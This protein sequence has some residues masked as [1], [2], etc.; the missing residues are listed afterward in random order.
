MK[1]LLCM[2]LTIL[3]IV[4][5]MPLS[6]AVGEIYLSSYSVNTSY[7]SPN[8]ECMISFGVSGVSNG[9]IAVSTDLSSAFQLTGGNIIQNVAVVNGQTTPIPFRYDG[10]SKNLVITII[11]T[12]TGVPNTQT[13]LIAEAQE[14]ASMQQPSGSTEPQL[15]IN[16]NAQ[17][18][19]PG[20][21]AEVVV[22]VKN[23]SNYPATNIYCTVSTDGS[24]VYPST[25][26]NRLSV[27]TIMPGM[28]QTIA[29]PVTVTADASAGYLNIGLNF[30]Y[31]GANGNLIEQTE[32]IGVT[33]D[34]SMAHGMSALLNVSAA[35]LEQTVID[36]SNTADL[37]VQLHNTGTWQAT[38]IE[39]SLEG[40]TANG[41][42]LNDSVG[43]KRFE[44][45]A[46]GQKI[47]TSFPLRVSPDLE[48]GSHS[49]TVKI[50]Y[51]NGVERVETTEEV[52]L[53]VTRN[54]SAGLALSSAKLNTNTPGSSNRVK[55][56]LGLVNKDT[57]AV[58]NIRT[59]IE[60][61]STATFTLD[62]TFGSVDLT[63]L[64]GGASATLEFPLYVSEALATGNYPLTVVTKYLDASGTEQTKETEIYLYINRP[65]K[66]PDLP[67]ETLPD[68]TPR[69][70]ISKYNVSTELIEAGNEFTLDFTLKNTS[71]STAI[72]N[73]KIGLSSADGVYLPVEGSSSFYEPRIDADGE[74]DFSIRL[75][76]KRDAET[77][78]YPLTI[79]IDY[80]NEKNTSYNVT[81]TLSFSVN[82]EQRLELNNV[83]FMPNGMSPGTLSLQYINKGKAVLYN[84]SVRVEGPFTSEYGVQYIGNFGIGSSD[85]F[86]DYLTPTE[87]GELTGKLI[88]EF[89]DVNGKK[90]E[91]VE[92]FTAFIEE[93]IIM[94]DPGM[95]YPEDIYMEDMYMEEPA[96]S[97]GMWLWIGIAGGAVLLIGGIVVIIILRR[98]HRKKTEMAIDE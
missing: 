50:S 70:I 77:K 84:M 35:G 78:T 40:Y 13:I 83:S 52:F 32:Q 54:P 7:I 44:L 22:S 41:F 95:M 26:S 30:S 85:Y 34:D 65:E 29:I 6:G 43:T 45:L 73:L 58:S 16:G 56:T 69:V 33:I 48:N 31:Y 63:S 57:A 92:E 4:S 97:G 14:S 67:Q 18:L 62:G 82:Q 28:T 10:S 93:P 51:H 15:V 9:I 38:Q 53:N 19:T 76:P 23:A 94:D 37:F 87:T 21:S 96:S 72:K 86:E 42:S 11:N 17:T 66:E 47:N 20:Q 79:T 64:A 55:L 25:L 80:E 75:I 60:G 46:S 3:L 39:V 90:T 91:V 36:S 8:S 61:L 24:S 88:V 2:I 27:G 5:A 98:K 12:D 1:K 59:Q 68:S 49:M 81:E 89:E 71:T 74:A